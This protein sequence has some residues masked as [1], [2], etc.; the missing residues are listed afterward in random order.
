MFPSEITSSSVGGGGL[1]VGGTVLG[2]YVGSVDGPLGEPPPP[3]GAD[4]LGLPPPPVDADPLGVP[5]P[6]DDADCVSAT[7]PTAV[8]S[9]LRPNSAQPTMPPRSARHKNAADRSNRCRDL[10]ISEP[11]A[12]STLVW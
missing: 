6:S 9:L 12:R 1:V 2:S 7:G 5:P 10:N 3:V 11:P 4:R 8:G